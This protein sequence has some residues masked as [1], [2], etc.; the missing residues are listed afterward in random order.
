MNEFFINEKIWRYLTN[1]WTIIL[2]VFL[3]FDF[4]NNN[5]F[6]FL[7]G[8]FA[9]IY[10]GVLGLFVSS[11]EFDRWYDHRKDRHP[12]EWYIVAWTV[13]IV[14]LL[15][16]NIFYNQNYHLPSE[17]IAS[18]IAVLGIFAIT[19]KS[20]KFYNRKNSKYFQ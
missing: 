18:Y 7:I 11:K 12:G 6:D 16:L 9:V 17:I 3:I 10:L 20:K 1:F 14:L 13:L 8:P 5:R 2:F 19:Q 15:F 4:L